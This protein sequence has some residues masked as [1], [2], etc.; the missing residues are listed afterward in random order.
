[1]IS[2]RLHET[3]GAFSGGPKRYSACAF[4]RVLARNRKLCSLRTFALFCGTFAVLWETKTEDRIELL[5]Q[6]ASHIVAADMIDDIL[7]STRGL[8]R[9]LR[10][11]SRRVNNTFV[12]LGKISQDTEQYTFSEGQWRGHSQRIGTHF[13]TQNPAHGIHKYS[14]ASGHKPARIDAPTFARRRSV[15]HSETST[16]LVPPYDYHPPPPRPYSDY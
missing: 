4:S 14:L 12:F 1:M 9:K 2:V 16:A 15:V 3:R 6:K 13:E 5:R 7:A 8:Q 10:H 11:R